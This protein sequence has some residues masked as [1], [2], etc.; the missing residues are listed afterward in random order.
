MR[1][2]LPLASAL[3]LALGVAGAGPSLAAAPCKDA[4]GKFVKCAPAAP[5][6]KAPCKDAKGKFMKCPAPMA[7]AAKPA[8]M[9]MAAKP[10]AKPAM[11]PAPTKH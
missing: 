2:G 9:A 3:I 6:K 4:K 10:A 1:I 5:A 11:A 8:P 7:A